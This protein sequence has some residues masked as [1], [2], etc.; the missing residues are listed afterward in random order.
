MFFI[1]AY[2]TNYSCL[3]VCM[4]VWRRSCSSAAGLSGD[5]W[6][7]TEGHAGQ[8]DDWSSNSCRTRRPLPHQN[9][10]GGKAC[11]THQV[12]TVYINV[13][14]L[15]SSVE[16]YLILICTKQ[17]NSPWLSFSLFLGGLKKYPC[18]TLCIGVWLLYS[19]T[20]CILQGERCTLAEEWCPGVWA[21]TAGRGDGER[22]QLLCG[23]SQSVQLVA[24]QAQLQV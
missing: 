15:L 23:L 2:I 17:Q 22:R 6:K 3:C 11:R 16:I 12:K 4:Q 10:F 5:E 14:V 20:W 24:P 21:E 19:H 18:C 13:D 7:S 1:F 8:T 9:H